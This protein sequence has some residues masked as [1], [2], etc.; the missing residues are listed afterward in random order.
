MYKEK[1][2]EVE[3]HLGERDLEDVVKEL[4]ADV[5]ALCEMITE[6]FPQVYPITTPLTEGWTTPD[7]VIMARCKADAR[8]EKEKR[9]N[10]I[11]SSG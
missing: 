6:M 10:P 7:W 11:T 9:E 5:K 2:M 3:I 8:K 4:Q 1:K